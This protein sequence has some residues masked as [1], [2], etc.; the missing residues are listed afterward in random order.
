M[1]LTRDPSVRRASTIG[2]DSSMRRPT[3]EDDLIDRMHQVPLVIEADAGLLELAAAL[4]VDVLVGV[5]ED[6]RDSFVLEQ[7]LQRAKSEHLVRQPPAPA[8]RAPLHSAGYPVSLNSCWIMPNSCICPAR[9]ALKSPSFSKSRRLMSS[10]W[11]ADLICC[12][13]VSG[14]PREARGRRPARFARAW[15]SGRS[16]KIRAFKLLRGNS[17]CAG[18]VRSRRSCPS[19]VAPGSLPMLGG[20]AA[21]VFAHLTICAENSDLLLAGTGS[22]RFTRAHQV[23]I[24]VG[25]A[26]RNGQPNR[27][28][29]L[30]D[31]DC[32][33]R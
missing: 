33:S 15:R 20:G 19:S 3:A 8:C 31:R 4:N 10:L 11:T 29:D 26:D 27:L 16:Q 7:R 23:H 21:S 22:P 18:S 28:L 25:Q 24:A 2:E 12:C 1:T 13:R 30:L 17:K 32:E 5:D 14:M 6:V 9:V